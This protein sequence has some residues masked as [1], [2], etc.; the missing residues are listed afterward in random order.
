MSLVEVVAG[1]VVLVI[2]FASFIKIINISSDMTQSSVDTRNVNNEL[3]EY[4]YNG[5]Y[6]KKDNN[7]VFSNGASQNE[8]FLTEWHKDG[9]YFNEWKKQDSG[10]FGGVSDTN[11]TKISLGNMELDIINGKLNISS[12]DF[13][14]RFVYKRPS[15]RLK[16]VES[17]SGT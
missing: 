13:F 7:D 1:F 6:D 9:D 2:A 3:K 16:P 12:T 17:G 5:Y 11:N 15:L 8:I 14:A 4:Y 10:N